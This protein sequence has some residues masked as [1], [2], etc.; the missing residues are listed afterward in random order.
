M[1]AHILHALSGDIIELHSTLVQLKFIAKECQ[2]MVGNV[3]Y[4]FSQQV[5]FFKKSP[6]SLKVT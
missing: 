3:I 2:G 4:T 5:F 6:I 1:V